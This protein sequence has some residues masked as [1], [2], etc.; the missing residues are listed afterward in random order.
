MRSRKE[1]SM[2]FETNILRRGMV[3]MLALGLWVYAAGVVFA[4]PNTG[5]NSAR[6]PK[7]QAEYE[8]CAANCDKTQI[9]I[10]NQIAL[11][12]QKCARDTDLY[13]SRTLTT[14]PNTGTLPKA[15]IGTLQNA[16]ANNPAP[17]APPTNAV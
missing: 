13:C 12:K 15:S 14:N 5:S 8:Q 11:C 10:G 1:P 6:S 2:I 17:K 16:P 9:D 3:P 7:C 4:E